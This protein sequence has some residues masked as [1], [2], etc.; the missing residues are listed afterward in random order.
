[1]AAGSLSPLNMTAYAID[2]H[3]RPDGGFEAFK[4]DYDGIGGMFCAFGIKWKWDVNFSQ[5]FGFPLITFEDDAVNGIIGS[6]NGGAGMWNQSSDPSDPAALTW[7][8][9]MD[10]EPGQMAVNG[11]F[12]KAIKKFSI[13]E[14]ETVTDADY[15]HGIIIRELQYYRDTYVAPMVDPGPPP[16]RVPPWVKFPPGNVG[17][18]QS[19][20]GVV[21]AQASRLTITYGVVGSVAVP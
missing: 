7:Q 18:I 13:R 5:V 10:S 21:G 1:M 16:G 6:A 14:I 19:G 15:F 8:Q 9:L 17:T 12:Q 4:V 3:P 2:P 11:A 20:E